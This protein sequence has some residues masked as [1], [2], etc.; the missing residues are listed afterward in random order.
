M[1][2]KFMRYL[3][4]MEN[5]G[6]KLLRRYDR[7][8]QSQ[9]EIL[10]ELIPTMNDLHAPHVPYHI[11]DEDWQTW[12]VPS[13]LFMQMFGHFSREM[14]QKIIKAM[15]RSSSF[16]CQKALLHIIKLAIERTPDLSLD[17]HHF[18]RN[19]HHF[20]LDEMFDL[21]L[22]E[23]DPETSEFLTALHHALEHVDFISDLVL[24]MLQKL[25][26][27]RPIP[28]DPLDLL[29]KGLEKFVNE[30]I[31]DVDCDMSDGEGGLSAFSDDNIEMA[32]TELKFRVR[33]CIE[34]FVLHDRN[35]R[36]RTDE[37]NKPIEN[38]AF[39]DSID[40]EEKIGE[41]IF[42][43]LTTIRQLVSV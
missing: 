21:V 37:S 26:H 36:N 17:L 38:M 43:L 40:V 20:N 24:K 29:T 14:N 25:K 39:I 12:F 9:P 18:P 8:L 27:G 22:A 13:P 35:G 1:E 30:S 2:Y 41:T 10:L 3:S 15:C 28:F 31:V 4:Q 34:C 42:E 16:N 33:C 32:T 6:S 5:S 7:E 11:T 19:D 23:A